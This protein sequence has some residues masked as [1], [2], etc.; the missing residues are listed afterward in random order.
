MISCTDFIPAYSEFFKFLEKRGG[1]KAVIDF[2]KYL[3]ERYLGNLKNLVK[4]YGIKGCWLYWSKTLSEEAASFRMELDEENGIFKIKMIRCPS[5]SRLIKEKHIKPYRDYCK[6][7]I[8]YGWI[9]EPLGYSYSIDL[10]KTDRA[11][12]SI[13]VKSKKKQNESASI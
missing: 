3:S 9:L 13:V 11:K 10:S 1:K 2:W 4:K 5:K 12:C 6:H 8:L 7:C